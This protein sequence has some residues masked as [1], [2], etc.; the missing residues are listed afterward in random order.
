MQQKQQSQPTTQ[1]QRQVRVDREHANE[2]QK[3][4]IAG[5]DIGSVE[6][7][8]RILNKIQRKIQRRK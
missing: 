2:V 5:F 8:T 6:I 7:N 3:I 1:H 4:E